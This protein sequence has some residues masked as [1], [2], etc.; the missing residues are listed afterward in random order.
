MVCGGSFHSLRSREINFDLSSSRDKEKPTLLAKFFT[1]RVINVEAVTRTFKPLWRSKRGFSA[2]DM[3]DNL[4]LFEFEELPALERVHLTELWSYDKYLVS[5]QRLLGEDDISQ[6][7]FDCAT[8]WV[9][10]HNLP[11]QSLN[12]KTAEA[13]GEAIGGALGKVVKT[14][15]FDEELEGG[16]IM[17]VRISLNINNPLCQGHKICLANGRDGWISFQY[18]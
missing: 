9:Q 4:M 16:C 15:T 8:F 11:F 5:F 1:R 7:T 2:R 17:R 3:G 13:I 10:I 12:K 14:S 18:K 6:V